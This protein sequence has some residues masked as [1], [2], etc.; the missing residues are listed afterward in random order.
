MVKLRFETDLN[1]SLKDGADLASA[2]E[3]VGD[4]VEGAVREMNAL[5][6]A[7]KRIVDANL[8]PQEKYNQKLEAM[9]KAVKAGRLSME[10]AE[11]TAGRLRS[12]LD[13]TG[14]S[15]SSAFG[16]AAI[17]G[18]KSYV[19]GMVSIGLAVNVVRSE[20]EAAQAAAEKTTQAQLT[21]AGAR[22]ILKRNIAPAG[23]AG[24]RLIE[25]RA[26]ALSA[27]L[28]VS[29][30][31]IDVGLAAAFSSSDSEDQAFSRVRAAA[32]FLKT[33]PEGIGDFAG[34]LGDISKS[35]K[36]DD[37]LRNLGFL[38]N[39]SAKSR[40]SDDQKFA[41][42][43]PKMAAGMSSFGATAE[44]SGALFDALGMAAADD[45]GRETGTG[46]IQ[47]ASQLKD[48]VKGGSF[49]ERLQALRNDPNLAR[50]F[51]EDS[52]FESKIKGPMQEFLLNK[53]SP[54][55]RQ[56]DQL[57]GDFGTPDQQRAKANETTAY[58][59]EGRTAN[60][61][62]VERSISSKTEQFQLSQDADLSTAS[63]E[64]IIERNRQLTGH[65]A[66]TN[67]GDTWLRSGPTMSPQEAIGELQEGIRE[68]YP[69]TDPELIN[70]TREMIE[71]L[72]KLNDQRPPKP[73]GR[74]E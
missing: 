34:A 56:F 8:T 60:A 24:G 63:R 5:E 14:E 65:L 42:A 15:Q 71:E 62:A 66:W 28:G 2:F 72:R 53:D 29:Q 13:K 19:T 44:E 32:K 18:L 43:F 10:E 7:A 27:E 58:L 41:A 12:Q 69:D 31:H 26:D 67:R 4:K 36:S 17:N 9:A 68:Q 25:A 38:I 37:D 74:Q 73:S 45:E 6:K 16:T 54:I 59:D 35:T 48:K 40:V 23:A 11:K 30:R 3:K 57:L 39:V 64:A 49:K 70:N 33:R 61:A 22:D 55:A 47:L 1:S 20:I 46:G 50:K 21:A 52:S 51:V